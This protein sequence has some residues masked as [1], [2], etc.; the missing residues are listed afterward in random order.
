M[1]LVNAEFWTR[2]TDTAE[3]QYTTTQPFETN[4]DLSWRE[5]VVKAATTAYENGDL[6]YGFAGIAIVVNEDGV[7]A[8]R[9]VK[10]VDPRPPVEV[11]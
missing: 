4:A 7:M 9:D 6:G 3:W 10:T 11:S 2:A 5:E 8:V 1:A